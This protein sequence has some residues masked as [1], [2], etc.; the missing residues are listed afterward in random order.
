MAPQQVGPIEGIIQAPPATV[1]PITCC[2]KLVAPCNSSFDFIIHTCANM[3]QSCQHDYI[4]SQKLIYYPIT[5]HLKILQYIVYTTK[6]LVVAPCL[7]GHCISEFTVFAVKESW[8]NPH[9][10]TTQNPF[11]FSFHLFNP[12]SANASVCFFLNKSL[13]PSSH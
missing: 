13:N 8:Q 3:P 11:N 9:I 4:T 5:S 10:H 12:S 7:A 1:F 6:G 2:S